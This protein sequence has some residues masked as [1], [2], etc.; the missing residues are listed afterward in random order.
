MPTSRPSPRIPEAPA[1]YSQV[2]MQDL[3]RALEVVISQLNNPGDE[4]VSSLHVVDSD[5][6][7]SLILPVGKIRS[8]TLEV[9][10]SVEFPQGFK[11]SVYNTSIT[12]TSNGFIHQELSIGM[13]D[14]FMP[15]AAAVNVTTA[16][17][18]SV[19]LVD[20][21]QNSDVDGYVDGFPSGTFINST[22]FKGVFFC[23]G[24]FG[25][26]AGSLFSSQSVPTSAAPV[27]DELAMRISNNAGNACVV[28]FTLLGLSFTP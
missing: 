22:G 26:S 18:N 20:L 15:M 6:N 28:Q 11:F 25:M 24:R 3:S 10:N 27:A 5:V 7:P 4:R 23:Q 2:Y 9:T 12:T 17:A 8:D 14:Y 16:A 21:G 1:E 13:P 19:T